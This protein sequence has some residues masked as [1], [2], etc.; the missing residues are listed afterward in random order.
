VDGVAPHPEHLA[1]PATVSNEQDDYLDSCVPLFEANPA[2]DCLKVVDTR[3]GIDGAPRSTLG[4]RCIPGPLV[5]GD[6][7]GDF[8]TP[9][10]AITELGAQAFQQIQVGSIPHRSRPGER[11]QRQV[12][13]DG[14][15]VPH[16]LNVGRASQ[17][18]AFQSTDTRR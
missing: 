14:R 7:H 3:L 10:Q 17:A 6:G 15:T 1:V 12:E 2:L 11:A 5:A 18:V 13:A 8:D 16:Q 9:D 4:D